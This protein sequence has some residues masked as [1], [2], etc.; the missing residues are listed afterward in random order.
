MVFEEQRRVQV[1]PPPPTPS[2]S[3][4]IQS[5]SPFLR[6]NLRTVQISNTSIPSLL[7]DSASLIVLLSLSFCPPL[8]VGKW[9]DSVW[10]QDQV[11]GQESLLWPGDPRTPVSIPQCSAAPPP[12]HSEREREEE[13]VRWWWWW[14]EGGVLPKVVGREQA[15]RN[16]IASL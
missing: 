5:P 3:N 14:V 16:L 1:L 4:P 15:A 12:S 7:S 10:K 9:Q 8:H 11:S 13:R 6:D 2:H